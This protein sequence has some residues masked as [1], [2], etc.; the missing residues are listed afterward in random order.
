[1]VIIAIITF[2]HHHFAIKKISKFLPLFEFDSINT[3]INITVT[4]KKHKHQ[5]KIYFFENISAS[6]GD[7][8]LSLSLV[9]GILCI[10]RVISHKVIVGINGATVLRYLLPCCSFYYLE[11]RVLIFNYCTSISYSGTKLSQQLY[12][13]LDEDNIYMA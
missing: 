7:P 13:R 5:N 8:N 10:S 12:I 2:T 11:C 6:L 4:S 3:P 9:I 1:M